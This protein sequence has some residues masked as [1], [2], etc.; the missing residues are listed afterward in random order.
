MDEDSLLTPL[1][2]GAGPRSTARSVG[3][4]TLPRRTPPACSAVLK[5]WPGAGVSEIVMRPVTLAMGKIQSR[6]L[7]HRSIR[8]Q[9]CGTSMVRQT[10]PSTRRGM[11]ARPRCTAH[12][13]SKR[14]RGAVSSRR[15]AATAELPTMS[16]A[17]GVLAS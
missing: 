2:H 17:L 1:A 16:Y 12:G 14:I 5:H 11:A 6:G 13:L 8:Q 7:T 10:V 15:F 4:F 9:R 3:M